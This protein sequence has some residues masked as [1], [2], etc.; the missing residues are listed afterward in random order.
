MAEFVAVLPVI[1]RDDAM[2]CLDSM[3][4]TIFDRTLVVDNTVDNRG[5]AASWNLGL[6]CAREYDVDYLVIISHAIEFG[7][8]SGLDLVAALNNDAAPHGL[9]TQRG[10]QLIA[11]GRQCWETI[12][13]FDEQFFAY[14]E[15]TDYLYRLGLA[16]LP[17]P[18]ENGLTWPTIMVDARTH[19]HGLS[20]TRDLIDSDVYQR[21]ARTYESKW[22]GVQGGERYTRPYN[23]SDLDYRHTGAPDGQE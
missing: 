7:L 11:I 14:F 19:G 18:R 23:R 15:D 12:G 2:R 21:S 22:G 4:R 20:L 10:W 3:C 1:H 5:V 16:G 9:A 8:T 17:S 6:A 13:D